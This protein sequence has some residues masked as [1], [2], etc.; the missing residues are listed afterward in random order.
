MDE[1]VMMH[2]VLEDTEHAG[3]HVFNLKGSIKGH[4]VLNRNRARGHLTLMDDYFTL[5]ALFANH[6][7]RRFLMRKTV[8]D[9]LYHGVRSY[10]D[11]FILKKDSLGT[12]GFYGYRKCTTTLRMLAYGTF[13]DSWDEYIRMS[14]S[15]C[16]D[17]MVRFAIAV[18]EVFWTSAPKRTN[19]GRHR[20]ALGNLRS[21]KVARFATVV[22]KVFGPRYVRE[23]IVAE[24]KRLLAISE[25]RGWPC[26]LGSLDRMHWKCKNCAK[27][28]QGQYQGH[29]SLLFA[30]LTK[31]KAP[32]CHYTVNGHEY[33]MDYYLVDSIYSPWATFVNTIFNPVGQKSLTLPKDKKRLEKMSRGHLE[34]CR[35]ILQLFM[36]LLNNEIR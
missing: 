5:D 31:G 6:F 13:A 20:E 7:H 16:G 28:L 9:R 25:A 3:K 27:A 22:V 32:P 30:R 11:Y 18:V 21:K 14:E 10:D 12:I 17:A 34:F 19:R 8:F 36:D 29:R 4:R 33:N 35:P 15:T 24:I 23:P 2:S 26:L 1:M